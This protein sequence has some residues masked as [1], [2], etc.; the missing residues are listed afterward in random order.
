MSWGGPRPGAGRPRRGSEKNRRRMGK[1]KSRYVLERRIR[2]LLERGTE[3][4]EIEAAKWAKELLPYD[5]PRLN[6][7]TSQ[8]EVTHHYIARIPLPI[9]DID[10]WQKVAKAT[11]LLPDK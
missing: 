7:V 6:A 8:S 10:E 11:L 2:V 4:A 1:S 9:E 5:E 3:T